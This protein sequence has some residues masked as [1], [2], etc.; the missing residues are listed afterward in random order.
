MWYSDK[1]YLVQRSLV[2]FSL[3]AKQTDVDIACCIAA[4]IYVDSYFRDLGLHSSVIILMVT[5][6]KRFLEQSVIAGLA[7][8]NEDDSTSIFWTL[9]IGGISAIKKPE[10]P[11]FLEHIKSLREA[12]GLGTRADTEEALK[13]ILWSNEWRGHLEQMWEELGNS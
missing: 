12:L 10:R 13:K 5:K 8:Y 1:V 2:Y 9:V 6:L 11:W 4:S 3:D 7:G